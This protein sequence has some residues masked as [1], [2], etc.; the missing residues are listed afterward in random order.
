MTKSGAPVVAI[1]D[2]EMGNLFSVQ[3]ACEHAE[4]KARITSDPDDLPKAE[5]V[6]LPGVGAFGDAME[7]LKKTSMD[8]ALRSVASSGKPLLGICLGFQLLMSESCEFGRHSGLGIIPGTVEKLEVLPPLKIPQ[9]GWNRVWK[10]SRLNHSNHQENS[11]QNTPLQGLQD[12]QFMYFVHSYFV[13]PK[14][15]KVT[16]ST[17]RY[18]ELE[19]CSSLASG[20]VFGCQFHPERS[21]PQGLQIY[22]N[23]LQNL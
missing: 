5:A 15:P 3:Q 14:D 17:T 9:V 22:K 7:T 1:V 20:N 16:L 13:S 23:W 21:G 18:G 11:W 19:F 8:E 2:Y 10:T 6:I 4:A 12:G